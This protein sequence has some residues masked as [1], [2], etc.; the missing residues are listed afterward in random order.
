MANGHNSL[1]RTGKG[2][3]TISVILD[4]DWRLI[5]SP[6]V[7]SRSPWTKSTAGIIRDPPVKATWVFLHI[8]FV[9]EFEQKK[10]IFISRPRD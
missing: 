5:V 8:F 9:V 10:G 6:L 2:V 3:D 4:G 1:E 7:G